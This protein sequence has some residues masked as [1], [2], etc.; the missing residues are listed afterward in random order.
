M[1][2]GAALC[3][4]VSSVAHS[5]ESATHCGPAAQGV[6]LDDWIRWTGGLFQ[7]VGTL[8]AAVLLVL[9]RERVTG[10]TS[11][12]HRWLSSAVGAIHRAWN[13]VLRLFGRHP[14]S[15]SVS[16]GVRVGQ[17]ATVKDVSVKTNRTWLPAPRGATVDE[18]LELVIRRGR[19]MH[20]EMHQRFDH[21]AATRAEQISDVQEAATLAA[22]Q[23]REE[24]KQH[25][26]GGAYYEVA[27]LGL[28]AL[29]VVLATYAS[30]I[31]TI[32]RAI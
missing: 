5:L 7:V 1:N 12:A 28:M 17:A 24:T 20:R 27:A 18:W 6:T 11:R 25:I 3:G 32:L 10:E 21:E 23:V 30:G 8:A 16:F 13:R 14:S 26:A 29:G 31:A 19:G 4:L 9:L 2:I 22:E 15:R